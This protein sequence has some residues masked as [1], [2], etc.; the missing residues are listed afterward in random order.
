[1]SD[2]PTVEGLKLAM[3]LMGRAHADYAATTQKIIDN[4]QGQHAHLRA[5]LAAVRGE[6]RE[7]YSHPWNPRAMHV[8]GA[9][10]PAQETIDRYR[11]EA[12]ADAQ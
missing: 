9:L 5:T 3:E 6:I 1:V 11:R 8:L 12:E 7:L 10:Q 4:L 2:E